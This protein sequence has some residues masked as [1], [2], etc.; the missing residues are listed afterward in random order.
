MA[1]WWAA[2][3]WPPDSASHARFTVL[4]RVPTRPRCGCGSSCREAAGPAPRLSAAGPA[5]SVP[6]PP[7]SAPSGRRTTAAAHSMQQGVARRYRVARDALARQ[8]SPSACS[9]ATSQD[10]WRRQKTS[11]GTRARRCFVQ[12]TRVEAA[13]RDLRV[14]PDQAAAAR[15]SATDDESRDSGGGVVGHRAARTGVNEPP[16][17]DPQRRVGA[18]R[19]KRPACRLSAASPRHREAPTRTCKSWCPRFES[20]SRH[21]VKPRSRRGSFV[22]QQVA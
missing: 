15:R 10:V 18:G 17:D 13:C 21:S 12:L 7:S 20:G 9:C 2:P 1:R 6:A 16:R 5:V 3:N 11:G 4:D 8:Q 19:P 22:S 14:P